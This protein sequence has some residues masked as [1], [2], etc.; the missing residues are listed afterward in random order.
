MLYRKRCGKGQG[1]KKKLRSTHSSIY[2]ELKENPTLGST[3]TLLRSLF[4]DA[5]LVAR[6][7]AHEAAGK[8]AFLACGAF[9]KLSTGALGVMTSR[10]LKTHKKPKLESYEEFS[11]LQ[12]LKEQ[13]LASCRK[14]KDLR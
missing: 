9:A 5:A 12:T 3:A 14:T 6:R 10:W 4:L 1:C 11:Y 2:T 13:Y 8:A 7:T